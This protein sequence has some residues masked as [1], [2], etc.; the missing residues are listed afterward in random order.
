MEPGTGASGDPDTQRLLRL[1]YLAGLY[2][3]ADQAVDV[4]ATLLAHP[5]SPGAVVWRFGVFGLVATRAT[6]LLVA[7][8][9]LFAAAIGLEHRRVL[10]V[11]GALH[12]VL[13]VAVAAALA[14]FGLDTIQIRGLVGSG[15]ERR[16]DSAAVRAAVAAALGIVV[17]GWAG[18]A[19]LRAG[20]A[21]RAR[22]GGW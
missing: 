12:L 7:D 1:L 19:S 18:I 3:I 4:A 17:L 15:A 13:A 14:V 22:V 11:L 21:M 9:M 10:R 6:T 5:V 20:R 8:V 2:I 16:F